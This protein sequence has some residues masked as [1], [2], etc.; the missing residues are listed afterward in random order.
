MISTLVSCGTLRACWEVSRKEPAS[1]EL[2]F[3]GRSNGVARRPLRQMYSLPTWSMQVFS[4]GEG[5]G[6]LACLHHLLP[7]PYHFTG[8]SSHPWNLELL[9]VSKFGVLSELKMPNR[10]VLINPWDGQTG[11]LCVLESVLGVSPGSSDVFPFSANPFPSPGFY[12]R[13]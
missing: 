6:K 9:L 4:K 13:C 10:R 3:S 7:P 11:V 2:A 12:P 1:S 5:M 8:T